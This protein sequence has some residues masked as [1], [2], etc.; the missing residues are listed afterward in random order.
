MQL[1]RQ[2][3]GEK[4]R[5]NSVRMIHIHKCRIVFHIGTEEG[6]QTRTARIDIEPPVRFGR[7]VGGALVGEIGML[8]IVLCIAVE[9]KLGLRESLWKAGKRNRRLF[10]RRINDLKIMDE[11]H[12]G[13]LAE[14]LIDDHGEHPP[15]AIL[16][17]H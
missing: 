10:L 13:N 4:P 1:L 5:R 8:K 16:V 7:G 14:C 15:C 9:G 3:I 2:R 11:T 12:S 17:L 6:G